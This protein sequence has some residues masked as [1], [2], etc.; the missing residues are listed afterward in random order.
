MVNKNIKIK[1]TECTYS[2]QLSLTSPFPVLIISPQFQNYILVL[3][4]LF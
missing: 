3:V 4:N 2:L 1:R